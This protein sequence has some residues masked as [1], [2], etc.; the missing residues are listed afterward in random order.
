MNDLAPIETL[1]HL[2]S[3]DSV[4]GPAKF[5]VTI[6]GDTLIV[7]GKQVRVCQA[8]TLISYP[9]TALALIW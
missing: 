8:P 5:D 9:G 7:N 2:L 1:A 3:F 6:D 4:H